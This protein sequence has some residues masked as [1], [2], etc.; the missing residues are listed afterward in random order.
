VNVIPSVIG[1]ALLFAYGGTLMWAINAWP[2]TIIVL[3]VF[4]LLLFDYIR[5]LRRGDETQM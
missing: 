1:I 4:A 5:I 3:F 2:F